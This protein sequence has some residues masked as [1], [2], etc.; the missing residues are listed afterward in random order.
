MAKNRL[1]EWS[2]L[3]RELLFRKLTLP[4]LQASED[5]PKNRWLLRRM[6]EN[7]RHNNPGLTLDDVAFISDDQETSSIQFKNRIEQRIKRLR[8]VV[9]KLFPGLHKEI[10]LNIFF[11]DGYVMG[12]TELA[13]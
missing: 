6:L 5:A 3:D 11:E 8:G 12:V 7:L 13:P 10:G 2:P 9:E 1:S 4:L